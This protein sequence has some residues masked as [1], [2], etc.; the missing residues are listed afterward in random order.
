MFKLF[1]LM[2]SF[3]AEGGAAGAAPVSEPAADANLMDETDWTSAQQEADETEE[4]QPEHSEPKQ[5]EEPKPD[6]IPD[7]FKVKYNKQ[8]VELTQDQLLEAA[9]KG[10]DY[11]RIRETRDRYMAPIE[12]LAQQA[13]MPTDQFLQKLDGV[14]KYNAVEDKRQV[15]I[16][17]GFDENAAQYMAELAYENELLKNGQA[18][19]NRQMNER[20]HARQALQNRISKDISDFEAKYPDVN[21]LPKEVVA[22][23]KNGEIPIVAYQAHLIRENGK[24]LKAFEQNQRNRQTAAGPVKSIGAE[25]SDPFLDGLLGR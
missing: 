22:E 19:Q 6:T 20:A 12:R 4:S 25:S 14:I 13:G 18:A 24:R 8:E 2:P 3:E 10:L 9:Q 5:P 11:D 15:L 1:N 7:R 23:I 21:T 16:G 17:Q